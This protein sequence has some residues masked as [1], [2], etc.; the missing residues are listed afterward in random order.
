MIFQ[1]LISDSKAQIR[2]LVENPNKSNQSNEINPNPKD[3]LGFQDMNINDTLK[4]N[5]SQKTKNTKSENGIYH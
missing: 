3:N 1:Y 5:F 2:I 4:I